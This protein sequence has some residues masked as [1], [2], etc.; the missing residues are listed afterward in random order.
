MSAGSSQLD[1][2]AHKKSVFVT[3]LHQREDEDEE[4][5]AFPIVKESGDRLIETGINTLQKTLLL[6]KEVE[7]EQVQ[8]ELACKRQE[9]KERMD[10]CTHHQIEVQKKQQQMKDRVAKFE[11]FIKENEAK[12]R[13]AIEKYQAEVKMKEQKTNECAALLEQLEELNDRHRYL[14]KKLASYKKYEDYL[15]QVIDAMPEDYIP[16]SEDKLKG[17]MMRHRTLSDSNK[18]LVSNLVNTS[19]ELEKLKVEL[20]ELKQEH[21]KRKV[22]NNSELAILQ[23]RQDSFIQDNYKKEENFLTGKGELRRRRTELGVILM[24]IDNIA[25]KCQKRLDIPLDKLSLEEKLAKIK[26]YL[27]EREEVARLADPNRA[28]SPSP[29]TQKTS[30]QRGKSSKKGKKEPSKGVRKPSPKVTITVSE[31]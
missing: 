6:K 11:K 9:F 7:I 15:L 4:F 19:D 27:C 12:R 26:D 28:G 5:R 29:D 18:G 23:K 25:D 2:Q 17:L 24:A 10:M 20:E 21:D 3:Q 13:R 8:Y 16:S 1:L 14:Q 22:S 30:P 31:T